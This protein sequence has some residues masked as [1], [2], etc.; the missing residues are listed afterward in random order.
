MSGVA[1]AAVGSVGGSGS[2]CSSGAACGASGVA[3]RLPSRVLEHIFS[4]LDLSDLMRCSL[5]CWHWNNCLADENSEVWRSQC[6]RLLSEEAL[7]SDILCNIASYK[8]KVRFSKTTT[9][10]AQTVS[11]VAPYSVAVLH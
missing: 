3:G 6:A 11:S 5:V 2:S 8:G 7:R 9:A 4:Y 1:A 10:A